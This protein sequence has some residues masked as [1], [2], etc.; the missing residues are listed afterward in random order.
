MIARFDILKNYLTYGQVRPSLRFTRSRNGSETELA[1]PLQPGDCLKHLSYV[2][3]DER[4]GQTAYL[5]YTGA[6]IQERYAA[7]NVR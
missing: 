5:R 3:F 1:T 7:K 2:P 4:C 6:L